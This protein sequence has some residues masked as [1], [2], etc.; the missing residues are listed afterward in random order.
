MFCFR[1]ARRSGLR[2]PGQ[3]LRGQRPGKPASPTPLL[4][5]SLT[6]V[7]LAWM[8]S[9]SAIVAACP[10]IV[11]RS[12][13]GPSQMAALR[14]GGQTPPAEVLAGLVVRVSFHNLENCFCVLRVKARG[15]RFS[16]RISQP[17]GAPEEEEDPPPDMA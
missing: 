14:Q 9:P 3:T 4:R 11:T 16:Q 7:P 5:W 10:T 6:Q 8:N 1:A 2:S 13:P 12:S 17:A 15:Q